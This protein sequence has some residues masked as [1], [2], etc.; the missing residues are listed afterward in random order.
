MRLFFYTSLFVLLLGSCRSNENRSLTD[1]P[2]QYQ[3]QHRPQVHFSPPANWMNDPNGMFYYEGEYHLFY[4]HYPDSNVWGPMHWGHAVSKDLVKWENLPIALYPDSLGMIFSGS[5]VV[6]KKNSSG[7]GSIEE[8]PLVAMYTYHSVEKEKAG[9]VDFQTQGI[10][11]STD[12]GT[13]WK[14]FAG[15]P[16]I[17]NPG[18]RDFRDPK[19]VWHEKSEKWIVAL[20]VQDHVEFWNSSDLKSWNKLSDFGKE[21]GSHGGVWECPELLKLEIDGKEK[22]VLLVSINPGGPNGGSATQ[23][24]VG[25]FDGKDFKADRDKSITQWLDYGPDNY[26]GVTFDN[27]PDGRR[28]FIGWMSNWAYAQTVPTARWRSATTAPRDLSLAIVDNIIYVRSNP[29]PEYLNAAKSRQSLNE[30]VIEDT[31]DVTEKINSDA[32]QSVISGEVDAKS[33]SLILSNV[34]SNKMVIGFDQKDNLFFVDR[35]ASGNT[36]FLNEFQGRSVAPRISKSDKINFTMVTD[37]SS[38]EVFFDD[39]LSVMTA[40]FF[41]DEKLS[42]LSITA[43]AK[44]TVARLELGRMK[45][46]WEEN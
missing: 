20:A 14:K 39:G 2:P 32:S 41:P 8:P 31:V 17:K 38:V 21:Y 37:V 18:I 33:F 30:L 9:R 29:S 35:S 23:Y 27:V 6:D 22:W 16:V 42:R 34:K 40:I 25:D 11:Y 1:A 45:S 5:A 28:I 3:E 43:P 24:F 19:I 26:A 12:K 13:T 4:Q 36:A 46:I 15:N 10:A 44:V 7:F